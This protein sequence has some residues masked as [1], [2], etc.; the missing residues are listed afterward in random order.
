MNLGHAFLLL[1]ALAKSA[2]CQ[3]GETA[4]GLRGLATTRSKNTFTVGSYNENLGECRGAVCGLW[5]DPHIISCDGL[6][7]DCNAKGLF[8][9]MKNSLYNIQGHFVE[10][11]GPE[12]RKVLGW[13]NYPSASY[14]N[15]LMI[16][17]VQETSDVPIMQFSFPNFHLEEKEVPSERGCYANFIYDRYM[18]GQASQEVDCI[19]S[20]RKYCESVT[21]CV[22][23][24]Y[25]YS[26]GCK[27]ADKNAKLKI[28]PKKWSRTVAGY[29]DRCGHEQKYEDLMKGTE[30]K[31][32]RLIGNGSDNK[33]GKKRKGPKC[34]FLYYEG[35]ELKDIHD[36]KNN[37][38]LYGKAGDK[39]FA[40]LDGHNKIK[41]QHTTEA[42]SLSE[43]MLEVGGEGPGQPFSCHWN[44]FVC[45]PA[46]EK[47]DFRKGLSLG[48]FGS[49]DG[50][51]YND[52]MDSTGRSLGKPT[53]VKSK[54]AYDYCTKN[55]CVE[56][57]DSLMTYPEY[58]GYDEVKCLYEEYV[59]FVLEEADCIIP[60]FKIKGAC[61][62]K[63]AP[64]IHGCQMD[65]CEGGCYE[66][67]DK[68]QE[69][70][71]IT[72]LSDK[73]EEEMIYD[74]N[75]EAPLC[76]GD[77]YEKTGETA[78]PSSSG[79]V[80]KSIHQT[81][82]ISDGESIV[83]GITF[84]DA[85]DDDHGRE[86]SFRVNNPFQTK[87]DTYVRYKK[88]VGLFA[89]DPACE[90]MA[91]LV[92]GCDQEAEEITVGCIENP[93]VE[94]FAIVDIYFASTDSFVVE[95]ADSGTE[96][97]KCCKAPEYSGVGIIKYTFKIQCSCPG[98]ATSD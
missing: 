86:V 11:S 31:K 51:K 87:A 10:V 7:Y 95:N 36:L 23:F 13:K 68:I 73:E 63:P 56:Q 6:T 48:L 71:N 58:S 96:I 18:Q 60:K 76:S 35:G 44:I 40:R 93:G 33:E 98:G 80:V 55:W 54:P 42:G 53:G 43:I 77:S 65:C 59:D 50:N 67:S 81:A 37:G 20:C 88:K 39:N 3:N 16:Q 62:D 70:Q 14:T 45:L 85:Q 2:D 75:K 84:A 61:E 92:P 52:W 1:F 26:H 8:T 66:I 49:P 69:I 29:V 28:K 15:D 34:P 17:N 12:M 30:R 91:D 47:V 5:G 94:P 24:S 82:N 25:S 9:L 74:V 27:L 64:L 46:N 21:G 41:I 57:K 79:S 19:E 72:H 97:E 4:P 32:A 90:S 89:N 38:Y 78:C 83:Y 22:K